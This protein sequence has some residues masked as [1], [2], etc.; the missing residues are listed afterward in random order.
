[1]FRVMIVEAVNFSQSARRKVAEHSHFH[2]CH[3]KKLKSPQK[4]YSLCCSPGVT[5]VIRSRK[6]MMVRNVEGIGQAIN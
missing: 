5:R 6:M 3:R 2:A 4:L 1:M